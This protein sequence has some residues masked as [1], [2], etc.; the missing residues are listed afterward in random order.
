MNKD[1]IA[2]VID[3]FSS[4]SKAE[5]NAL[6][7]FYA[8]LRISVN[9]EEIRDGI[10]VEAKILIE[11]L[12]NADNVKTSGVSPGDF[13][14][15]Y[16]NAFKAGYNKLIV[17]P[18][19]KRLSVT[20]NNAL[21]AAR[22]YRDQVVVMENN[23]LNSSATQDTCLV[24][25]KMIKEGANIKQ[26]ID[27]VDQVNSYTTMLIIPKNLHA[28]KRGGR[29][30]KSL[31]TIMDF[32]RI[33]PVIHYDGK[34]HKL[35]MLRTQTKSMDWS[36]N[37]IKERINN[38]TNFT[39]ALLCTNKDLLI[40]KTYQQKLRDFLNLN[41]IVKTTRVSALIAAHTGYASLGLL[42]YKVK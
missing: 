26:L 35:K 40:V 27:Y 12:R 34:I 42:L 19:T 18:C 10:D 15:A 38:R 31:S 36:M 32:F 28:L 24:M 14:I 11:K 3:S 9:G 16:E 6:G 23:I 41:V 25:L 17:L 21:L 4:W 5:A 20:V 29:I 1:K 22:D 39:C 30:P 7:I 8:P 37:W 2:I 33:V 13:K